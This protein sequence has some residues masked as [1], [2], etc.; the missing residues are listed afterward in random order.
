MGVLYGTS[1]EL[2]QTAWLVFRHR[3]P[4]PAAIARLPSPG[5]STLEVANRKRAAKAIHLLLSSLLRL[6]RF[7]INRSCRPF[8][9]E[10]ASRSLGQAA[11]ATHPRIPRPRQ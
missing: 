1:A 7:E 2:L 6:G 4:L 8:E 9:S 10:A 11:L 5:E 3:L